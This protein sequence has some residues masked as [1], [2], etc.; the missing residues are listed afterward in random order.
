MTETTTRKAEL[1]AK[2]LEAYEQVV[3]GKYEGELPETRVSDLLADLRHYC[4]QEG[5]DW[6]EVERLADYHYSAEVRGEE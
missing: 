1:A 4:D 2:T 5:I 6:S 3:G